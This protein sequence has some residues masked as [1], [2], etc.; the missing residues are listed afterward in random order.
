MV[1]LRTMLLVAT[2]ALLLS[3]SCKKPIKPEAIYGKWKYVKVENPNSRPID[4][5]SSTELQIQKPH[6]IFAKSDSMQIWWGGG[7]L[8]HGTFKVEGDK[9]KVKENI[10]EGTRAFNF[11]ISKLTDKELIFESSGVDGARVTAVKE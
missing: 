3:S 9:I 5:V 1:K 7:L 11:T 8:S 2:T 4:S 10:P 6:I